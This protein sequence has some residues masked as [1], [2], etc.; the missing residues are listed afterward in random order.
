MRISPS[1]LNSSLKERER[2]KLNIRIVP[3]TFSWYVGEVWGGLHHSKRA[4]W[5]STHIA[6]VSLS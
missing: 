4:I 5:S 2:E 3:S 1:L 6:F